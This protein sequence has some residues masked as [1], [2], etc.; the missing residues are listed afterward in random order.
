[1]SRRQRVADALRTQ[2]EL[3]PVRQRR[4]R[5]AHGHGRIDA[6]VE[7]RGDLRVGVRGVAD[8]AAQGCPLHRDRL[9]SIVGGVGGQLIQR[10]AAREQHR[11][12]A[13]RRHRRAQRAAPEQRSR[14][15][16]RQ[17]QRDQQRR[18]GE[19]PQ[20]R[21]ARERP[22]RRAGQVARVDAPDPARVAAHG[23]RDHRPRDAERDR[24]E[25]AY[26]RHRQRERRGD[27]AA[28]PRRVVQPHESGRLGDQQHAEQ[29]R[30]AREPRLQPVFR[31]ARAQ[32]DRER[33]R[34]DPEQ[35]QRD[36]QE[37]EVVRQHG[38]EHARQQHLH[39]ERGRRHEAHGGADS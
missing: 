8:H 28:D 15:S 24:G 36:R 2:R 27:V 30:P 1:M 16:R 38:R 19:P 22:D 3:A 17:R 20:Q 39:C 13:R 35:R 33:P 6:V 14:G 12:H 18:A 25:H 26:E 34:A 11:D 37:R 21:H 29:S 31:P 23:E 32:V 10:R 7:D 4:P 9:V 5:A